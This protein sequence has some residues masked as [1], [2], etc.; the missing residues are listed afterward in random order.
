[1]HPKERRPPAPERRKTETFFGLS[2]SKDPKSKLLCNFTIVLSVSPI[3]SPDTCAQLGTQP[4][5]MPLFCEGTMAMMPQSSL[6]DREV[7][8]TRKEWGQEE[9]G[10]EG[11]GWGGQGGE[12]KC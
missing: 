10:P 12:G 2:K 3:V 9:E 6:G 5:H 11:T 1:M 4:Q 8:G 7:P